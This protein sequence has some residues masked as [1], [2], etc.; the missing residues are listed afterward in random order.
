MSTGRKYEASDED[1]A[2]LVA[3]YNEVVILTEQCDAIKR[4]GRPTDED[5]AVADKLR[6]ASR[7]FGNLFGVVAAGA[8]GARYDYEA[9]KQAK[10]DITAQVH[11]AVGQ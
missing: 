11:E 7:D 4:T 2:K 5:Q 10:R 9:E 1:L 3:L 8:I 6:V